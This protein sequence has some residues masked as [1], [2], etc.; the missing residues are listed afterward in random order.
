[1]T[2]D[3]IAEHKAKPLGQHSDALSRLLNYFR[4]TDVLDKYAIEQ[5]GSLKE[6]K[7]KILAFT[8]IPGKPPRVV[9]E[10]I[11]NNKNEAYHAVFLMRI[12][13]LLES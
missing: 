10:R 8:G 5:I 2:D 1:V 3:V 4:R 11:Y 13:D 6:A 7:Y 12:N 9:D